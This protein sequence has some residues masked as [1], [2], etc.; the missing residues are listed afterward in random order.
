[1]L[2]I[3]AGVAL[4]TLT[5]QGNIIGNAEN[6]VGKYNN[7]VSSEQQLLNEIEK[8]LEENLNYEVEEEG[9]TLNITVSPKGITSKVIVTIEGKSEDGIKSYTTTSGESKTYEEGTKEIT[10]T[11][12]ISKNGTYTITIENSKGK[13]VSKEII[14]SN[15]LEGT[16]GMTLDKEMPTKD[17][18]KVTIIWPEGSEAGIK[19]I[20]VGDGEWETVTGETSTVEVE[21]N[22]TVEARVRNGE[23]NVI[24]SSITISNIDKNNPT[25]TAT[26]GTE[27]IKEETSIEISS[28][29]TYSS[30]GTAE[31]TSI[32]YT[33]TSNG[34]TVVTNTNTLAV[35]THTIKC[36]VTKETGLSATATKTIIVE[37]AIP[38]NSDGLATE[39]TTIKPDHNSDIQITIPAGFAPAILA[40]ETTQSLPGQDGSVK[41]IMPADQWNSITVEDI[42]KGIVIV[43]N[44]ITYDNG[45]KTGT[46]PDFNEY[47]WIPIS[48]FEED[49]KANGWDMDSI[50]INPTTDEEKQNKYWED[51]TTQ[52]YQNMLDSVEHYKGF[53]I[54]RY[55]ASQGANDVAQSKRN[56]SPWVEVSQTE[57]ITACVNNTTTVNMHLMYAI[58]WDSVLIWLKDN[59]I[60]SSSTTGETKI[61]DIDDIQTNSNSWGNYYDSTGDAATEPYV[62]NNLQNTGTSEYWKAN[63]IYDLAGNVWEWNQEKYSAGDKRTVRGGVYND[64]G[65]FYP[66]A[67]RTSDDYD[68]TYDAKGFRTSFFISMDAGSDG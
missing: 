50:V 3:L 48:N 20:K 24:A 36:T 12:E 66:V 54:G 15:I 61:M 16:I 30:N 51:T 53:Y 21:Q 57:G 46:I 32:T 37:T 42:N 35:G 5:G 34:D 43:D 25:V 41:S 33:D 49:F 59:A 62:K 60:I 9:I 8:Y 65:F 7:S 58:E 63:N 64:D 27:T 68:D 39:N 22:C 38:V 10:E 28:Y 40:T 13:T 4:V 55:E 67:Y 2:L 44:P 18:V 45:Q 17:N 29:F 26:S 19:E 47:V 6:A 31:I 52:E 1:M 14:I 11:I 56:I 23:E